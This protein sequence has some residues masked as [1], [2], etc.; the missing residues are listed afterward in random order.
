MDNSASEADLSG[1]YIFKR[2]RLGPEKQGFRLLNSNLFTF[3]EPKEREITP[4]QRGFRT[5]FLNE[6]DAVLFSDKFRDPNPIHRKRKIGDP[7]LIP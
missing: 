1:G 2:D 3:L 6:F 7:T 4:A 5:N